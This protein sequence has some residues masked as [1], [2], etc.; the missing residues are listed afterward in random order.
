MRRCW[1]DRSW[2]IN[3]CTRQARDHA[4]SGVQQ[5]QEQE[6]EQDQDQD[7]EQEWERHPPD[8]PAS[9]LRTFR[10]QRDPHVGDRPFGV[11]DP[12]YEAADRADPLSVRPTVSAIGHGWR[13]RDEEEYRCQSSSGP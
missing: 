9:I 8:A 12:G 6:Q 5:E 2:W 1:I 10:E 11:A 13:V 7:Q 4:S 3:G